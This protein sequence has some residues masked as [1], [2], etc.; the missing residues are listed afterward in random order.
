M[1]ILFRFPNRTAWAKYIIFAFKKFVIL[2]ENV[3]ISYT[4]HD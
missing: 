2:T 3:R 1:M 4:C